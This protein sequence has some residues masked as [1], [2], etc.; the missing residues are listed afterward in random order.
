MKTVCLSKLLNQMLNEQRKNLFISENVTNPAFALI[1][2]SAM[3]ALLIFSNYTKM[4]TN[5]G[6]IQLARNANAVAQVHFNASF[7]NSR[8]LYGLSFIESQNGNV[9]QSIDYLDQMLINHPHDQLGHIKRAESHAQVAQYELALKD[10]TTIGSYHTLMSLA[11]R[12]R[13]IEDFISA[14]LL[15]EL[16][17]QHNQLDWLSY[18]YLGLTLIELNE[19]E[20]A[21]NALLQAHQIDSNNPTILLALGIVALDLEKYSEALDYLSRYHEFFP[22]NV[23]SLIYI[24]LS[25]ESLGQHQNAIWAAN[26][27]VQYEIDNYNAHLIL[28]RNY[29]EVGELKLALDEYYLTSELLAGDD[30]LHDTIERLENELNR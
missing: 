5:L 2:I 27:I 19:T 25:Y 29:E 23:L 15:Y 12:A 14:K 26:Q 21:R 4:R 6:Y 10:W 1:A 30:F 16:A 9:W 3:L 11:D 28:A 7:S 13:Q 22:E 24:S 17:I 20:S 8:S 18:Y